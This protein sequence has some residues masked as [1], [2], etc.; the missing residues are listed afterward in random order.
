[1]I[2]TYTI[3]AIAIVLCTALVRW[4]L[5]WKNRRIDLRGRLAR[6]SKDREINFES[7]RNSAEKLDP[8]KA[9]AILSWDFDLLR[10]KLQNGDVSCTDVL[11]AYQR[12]ALSSTERTNCVCMFV[13]DAIEIAKSLDEKATTPGYRK[14]ALFGI[15]V[16]IK[17]NIRI[18]NMCSS[19]GYV[20]DLNTLTRK[21]AVLVEQLL[22]HGAVPFVHTNIPQSLV[23]YGCSNPIYG[24]T[25]NPYNSERVPGGSS[26]G[27]A[28]L[29]ATGG[30]LL[31]IGTDVGGSVRIPSTFCGIAGFKPS[32]VRFSGTFTPSSTPGRQQ[33]ASSEGPMAKSITTCIEYLKVTWSD[34]F[35]NDVDPFVPPV[36]WQE[37]MFSSQEKLRIGFY[38]HDG[39]VTPTPA[40]QRAVLE[41][42][43]ILEDL[44]HTVVSFR[45]PHPEKVFQL[46]VGGVSTDGG[47]YLF[48]KLI[49]DIVLP[50]CGVHPFMLMPVRVQRLIAKL[51]SYP[52]VK[53]LLTSLPATCEDLREVYGSIENYRSAF[54]TEMMA[55]NIEALLCPAMVVYPMKKG[56][57]NKLFAGCCYNAIFNLLDFAAGVIPFTKVNEDDEA[58]LASYP[59]N[60]PWDQLIK[61]DSKDCVGLPV[62]VQIAVPPYREELALRLL[63]EIELNRSEATKDD[64]N[65]DQ[66]L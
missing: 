57:P 8:E 22:H 51:V 43:Q 2:C 16:S 9:K 33:I 18:K 65:N 54:V 35:L 13:E 52:R 47:K 31:G 15:P 61:S 1:M 25:T 11:R 27:E 56:V 14:P 62:G 42:K 32:S 40:N 59:E 23:S 66:S 4:Y 44:G 48:N 37:E 3:T 26:G 60:D 20:Q 49:Q 53:A 39:F 7:A 45:V 63:R 64:I 24:A 5:I 17:E 46:F 21:N 55:Q 10:K 12:A 28:A 36:T 58:E 34:L 29:I 6:R 41:A 30:S 50:E 38:T 19:L